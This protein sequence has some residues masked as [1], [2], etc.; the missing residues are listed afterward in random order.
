VA[1]TASAGACGLGD[2]AILERPP[3]DGT[4]RAV[5]QSLKGSGSTGVQR[6]HLTT[7]R[8]DRLDACWLGVVEQLANW[9]RK[10]ASSRSSVPFAK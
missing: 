3:A 4:P 10:S 5:R 7:D 9:P 8:N 2:L 1:N 6:F